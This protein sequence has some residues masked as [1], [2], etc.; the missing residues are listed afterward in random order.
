MLRGLA[1][2][3]EGTQEVWVLAQTSFWEEGG[4]GREGGDKVG[5]WRGDPLV[6]VVG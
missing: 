3:D 2:E 4:G 6:V 5:E 1:Q